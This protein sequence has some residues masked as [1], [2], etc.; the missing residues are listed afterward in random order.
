MWFL[1]ALINFLGKKILIGLR[2]RIPYIYIYLE[3]FMY[4][5]VLINYIPYKTYIF[6][7]NT[8]TKN[9][10]PVFGTYIFFILRGYLP[11]VPIY[12]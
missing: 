2:Y 7:F 3:T 11:L 5:L 10:F 6:R 1:R 4:I 12:F 8:P 9:I